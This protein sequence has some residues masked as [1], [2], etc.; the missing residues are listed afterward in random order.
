MG[1]MQAMTLTGMLGSPKPT[2]KAKWQHFFASTIYGVL[3]T[4]S[5]MLVRRITIDQALWA[6]HCPRAVQDIKDNEGA[7]GCGIMETCQETRPVANL[8][9]LE[10]ACG[11]A[12]RSTLSCASRQELPQSPL[13]RVKEKEQK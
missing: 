13:A 11:G 10:R 1:L 12:Q 2:R 8:E 7:E 3:S 5:G 9:L 6:V 4:Q